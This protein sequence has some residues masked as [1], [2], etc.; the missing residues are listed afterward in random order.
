MKFLHD[1]LSAFVEED[2]FYILESS[3]RSTKWHQYEWWHNRYYKENPPNDG[4]SPQ[5]NR[6][7]NYEIPYKRQFFY[8]SPQSRFSLGPDPV[9][10]FSSDFSINCC[11]TI[12][13]FYNNSNL[14]WEELKAY[15]RGE[16]NPTPGWVGYPINIHISADTLLLDLSNGTAPF[17]TTIAG[18]GGRDSFE[19][20]IK[21]F[22]CRHDK[23]KL[24]TQVI[25]TEAHKRGFDAI[26]YPSVR[27]PKDVVLPD[28]NLVMFNPDKIIL[29]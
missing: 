25:S 18:K 14:T 5:I 19:K 26:I 9:A 6:F 22:R 3:R 27:A 4:F 23:D 24:A 10:Y 12:E 21:L 13:Q 29:S 8:P 17:L 11:E 15:F 20:I 28:W 7:G 2:W 1:I 16:G